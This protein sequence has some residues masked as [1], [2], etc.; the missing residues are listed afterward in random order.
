MSWPVTATLMVAAT[1]RGGQLAVVDFGGAFGEYYYQNL[2]FL[3]HLSAVAWHVVEQPA[4]AARARRDGAPGA[5]HFHDA[6]DDALRAG[7]PDV[8]LLSS[9]LQYLPDPYG[10]LDRCVA[11]RPRYVAIDRTLLGISVS[12]VVGMQV[13]PSNAY[14]PPLSQDLRLA[15][16]FINV[17]TMHQRLSP[18]YRLLEEFPSYFDSAADRPNEYVFRGFIY[19]RRADA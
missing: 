19:E 5:L 2:E 9:V 8:L 11:A 10:L 18:R 17:V 16:R 13:V 1:R 12:D 4:V 3:K 15:M 14:N 6:L 7:E